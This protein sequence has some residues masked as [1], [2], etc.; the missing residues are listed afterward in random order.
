MST[1]YWHFL[2]D[3]RRLQYG[4]RTLVRPGQTLRTKKEPV[5][6]R[7]GFHFSERAIDALRYA[8]G[9]VICR[10]TVGGKVV[11]NSDKGAAQERTV[12]WMAD[13]TSTLHEFAC[14]V[15]EHAL[16]TVEL[17]GKPVDP[18]SRDAIRIKRL[19]LDGKATDSELLAAYANANAANANTA[20]AA[21]AAAYA[22]AANAAA[23]YADA[24]YADA[25]AA[26]ANA[27]A[28]ANA[29]NASMNAALEQALLG[30]RGSEYEIRGR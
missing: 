7:Q 20:N 16:D 12:V 26:Y 21:N 2:P 17:T 22:A 5:P 27:Y 19:W 1:E 9:A 18:R 10:V 28:N 13:A 6:C 15:A 30:L 11:K 4:R 24:A 29:V 3:D 8:P 25:A 23:A 14:D